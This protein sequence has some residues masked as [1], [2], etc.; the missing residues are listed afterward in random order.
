MNEYEVVIHSE[1]TESYALLA[2]NIK[3]I[4]EKIQSGRED[5]E[6]LAKEID[7]TYD[8]LDSVGPDIYRISVR[9]SRRNEYYSEDE[10]TA[11][12]QRSM[13]RHPHHR[14]IPKN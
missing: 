4:R 5:L 12:R 11:M 3:E 9:K 6:K 7:E 13:K 2:E 1:S 10:V 8:W 14:T